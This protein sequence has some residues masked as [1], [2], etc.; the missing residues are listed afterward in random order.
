MVV[1]NDIDIRKGAMLKITET[2]I[3]NSTTV[4]LEWRLNITKEAK[5]KIAK[6]IIMIRQSHSSSARNTVLPGS[7]RSYVVTSLKPRTKYTISVIAYDFALRRKLT[8]KVTTKMPS[9]ERTQNMKN[10]RISFKNRTSMEIRWK[11]FN[12]PSTSKQSIYRIE[13]Y[14]VS[15]LMK[16]GEVKV[17]KIQKY[18]ISNLKASSSYLIHVTSL[19]ATADNPRLTIVGTT[20]SLRNVYHLPPDFKFHYFSSLG[21]SGKYT[22]KLAAKTSAGWGKSA[23]QEVFINVSTSNKETTPINPIEKQNIKATSIKTATTTTTAL[24]P[25][26]QSQRSTTIAKNSDD[27]ATYNQFNLSIDNIM[28]NSIILNWRYPNLSSGSKFDHYEISLA[29]SSKDANS[30]LRKQSIRKLLMV[31]ITSCRITKLLPFTTYHGHIAVIMN[32]SRILQSDIQFTTEKLAPVAV[33][34]IHVL[35]LKFLPNQNQSYQV[36]VQIPKVSEAYGPISY[37]DLIIIKLIVVGR[38]KKLLPVYNLEDLNPQFLNRLLGIQFRHI[39][40]P[41]Y[42]TARFSP[43]ELPINFTIGDNTTSNSIY[44]RPLLSNIKYAAIL[45]AYVKTNQVKDSLLYTS[46]HMVQ[47]PG[48]E[49]SLELE[50]QVIISLPIII[51]AGSALLTVVLIV[52][53]AVI[54]RKFYK[55]KHPVAV[56]RIHNKTSSQRNL[57]TIVKYPVKANIQSDYTKTEDK[58]DK[59]NKTLFENTIRNPKTE[60]KPANSCNIESDMGNNEAQLR[61]HNCSVHYPNSISI[62]QTRESS[63]EKPSQDSEPQLRIITCKY[64]TDEKIPS[65]TFDQDHESGY[66]GLDYDDSMCHSCSHIDIGNDEQ[67]ETDSLKYQYQVKDDVRD[68]ISLY[69]MRRQLSQHDRSSFWI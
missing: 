66:V 22:I 16:I 18:L 32:D 50:L 7:K 17:K 10:I 46:S 31:N 20:A 52:L 62:D 14:L 61:P 43:Q 34:K 26:K 42:V 27:Q 30:N 51:I 36:L 39:D 53:V 12:N 29:A 28:P 48:I 35:K 41:A 47:L 57:K 49:D 4:I 58:N 64:P 54:V 21:K 60:N 2:K 6:F 11:F 8:V 37:Y 15:N 23:S 68:S 56:R 5:Y 25:T 38:D 9:Q 1:P 63:Q 13:W 3:I 69:Q 24:L 44:N 45:R 19:N 33:E 59:T 40:L 65:N 67:E 55:N